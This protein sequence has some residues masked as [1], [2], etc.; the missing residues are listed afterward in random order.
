M[1]TAPDVDVRRRAEP[2]PERTWDG[3]TDPGWRLFARSLAVGWLALLALFLAFGAR[4]STFAH[5]ES[6]L[7]AGH[8]HR[9][10][11]SG[12]PLPPGAHGFTTMSVHWRRWGIPFE[13]EVRVPSNGRDRPPGPLRPVTVADV[14]GRLRADQPGVLVTH[15]PV[16]RPTGNVDQWHVP[17]WL[18]V[19]TILLMALTL[20]LLVQGPAP[21]RATRWAWFWIVGLGWLGLLPFFVLGGPAL[22]TRPP[23]RPERRV[24]GFW[25]FILVLVLRVALG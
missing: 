4:G 6:E 17:G 13:A 19:P 11:V 24:T 3:L 18:L 9:V 12:D 16:E 20:R 10:E 25:A 21:W 23:R 2:G 15:A 7:R 1:T 22:L 5:L 8:V 14:D